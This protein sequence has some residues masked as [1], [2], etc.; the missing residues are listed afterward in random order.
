M[1]NNLII[2]IGNAGTNIVKCCA[3]SA[4]LADVKMYAID[5]Q[6]SS[7]DATLMDQITFIPIISDEKNGSGRS[8]ARGAAMFQYHEELGNFKEMYQA[9]KDAKSPV[10][11]ITSAAGGTGSGASVPLC[12]SLME[13]GVQ[14]IPII[15]CPNMKD[16][17]AYHLNMN[18]LLL[19]MQEAGIITYSIFRNSRGDADYTVVNN[20]VVEL[21]EIVFGKR[22]DTTELDSID[23]SDIDTVMQ[24]PGRFIAIGCE[25]HDVESLKKEITRK[26]RTGFQPSWTDEEAASCTFMT[27]YSLTS[28]FA[29]Q[30]FKEVFSEVNSRIQNVFDEYRN[31]CQDD[32]DG[33]CTA[34][35]LIAGLPRPEIKQIDSEFYEASSIGAGIKKSARPSF[36][37]KKKATVSKPDTSKDGTKD[38]IAKFKWQ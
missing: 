16:P 35:L 33:K 9:A 10:F 24:T 31:I 11:V 4:K 26:L 30:D 23:D 2:G 1:N 25:A 21:I 5:S 3:Q 17:D 38:A 7:I 12:K 8:R 14:V 18:D 20:D 15:V 22:Y 34:T 36:M 32:N 37:N 13:L 19:E 27:A 29:K 6:T 28:L